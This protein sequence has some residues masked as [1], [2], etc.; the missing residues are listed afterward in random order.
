MFLMTAL[1]TAPIDW[2][3][4]LVGYGEVGRILAG[5]SSNNGKKKS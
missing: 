3:I 4:D 2:N 5:I 1:S